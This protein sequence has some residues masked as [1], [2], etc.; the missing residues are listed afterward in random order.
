M[1]KE[2]YTCPVCGALTTEPSLCYECELDEVITYTTPRPHPPDE[3]VRLDWELLEDFNRLYPSD[4]DPVRPMGI[5]D[6][7]DVEASDD[8]NT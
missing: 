1:S 5:W 2:T 8:P 4:D 6:V 3:P 7:E